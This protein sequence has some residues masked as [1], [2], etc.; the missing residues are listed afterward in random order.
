MIR[1]AKPS[2]AHAIADIYNHYIANT[3]V[4]FEEDQIDTLE[5]EKRIAETKDLDLPYLVAETANG[6]AGYAYA[7]KWNGRCA[8]K[9][10][11]EI[12]VYLSLDATRQGL[13]TALYEKLFEAL[14][15][16]KYHGVIAGISLPNPGSV[17][18]H[19]QF[20]MDKV[21]HFKEVGFK[22][23]RWVDVGYWQGM[24]NP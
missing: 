16:R 19:E 11:A 3:V 5:A 23:D 6:I 7:S 24:L 8:Y 13:G 17:A 18:L 15:Q 14:R 2:D 21:A 1:F 20:G 9:Y 10:T 22:F 4:S 12:T